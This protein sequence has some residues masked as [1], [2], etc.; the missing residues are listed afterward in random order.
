LKG[1]NPNIKNKSFGSTALHVAAFYGHKE[2][3]ELLLLNG[4]D[5]NIKNNYNSLPIDET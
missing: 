2:I 5:Y 3:V 1:C 4:A